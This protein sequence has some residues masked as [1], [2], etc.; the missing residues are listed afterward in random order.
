[1]FKRQSA[2]QIEFIAMMASLMAV[3]AL[4][5]DALLPAL[6]VIGITIGTQRPADN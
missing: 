1:M 3:V 4:A 5:I 6:D 2:S